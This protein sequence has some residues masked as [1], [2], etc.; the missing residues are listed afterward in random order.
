MDRRRDMEG[1]KMRNFVRKISMSVN[2]VESAH[3]VVN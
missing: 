1:F 3:Q 2:E